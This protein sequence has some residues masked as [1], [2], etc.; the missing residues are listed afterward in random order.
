MNDQ[1]DKNMNINADERVEGVDIADGDIDG[2]LDQDQQPASASLKEAWEGNPLLKIAAVVIG[3]GVLAGGYTV[4]F[5]NKDNT[6][7]TSSVGGVNNEGTKAVAGQTEVDA[8]YRKALEESNKQR[9]DEAIKTNTSA[10]PTPIATEKSDNIELPPVQDQDQEDPLRE[11]R[12]RNEARRQLEQPE[13]GLEDQLAA[14][15]PDVVPLVQPVRPQVQAAVNP[16]MAKALSEQMRVI[17]SAQ[18]PQSSNNIGIT[19]IKSDYVKMQSD[20]A[21]KQAAAASGTGQAAGPNGEVI[22]PE[23]EKAAKPKI[24][25]AAGTIAYAQLLNEL[26]SDI[27][28]PVLAQILSGP[29]EGGRAIGSFEVRDEYLVLSFKRIVKQGVSYSVDGVALNEDTTLAAH[30]SDVDYH[31]FSRIVL[32]AASKFI[33][34]YAAANA[35][36]GTTSTT[37][38]GGG[39]VQD[40]PEPDTNEEF[41]KGLEEGAKKVSEILD[42]DSDRPITVK[43]SRGTTMGILF[44][45]QVTT[46]SAQ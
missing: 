17:V 6:E 11:W 45:E 14:G 39:V 37:T 15:Q 2:G 41:K 10:M 1:E 28:G 12:S 38:A 19:P 25:V 42:K 23:A 40:K 43:V 32:P 46:S 21:A 35:E 44:M 33:E 36:T 16:E 24:I 30:Q 5:G 4:F 7:I 34:G 27:K 26:N 18:A 8:E 3:L 29:F 9:A 22:T 20:L 13:D 31:Y